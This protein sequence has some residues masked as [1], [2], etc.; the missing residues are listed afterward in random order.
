M[1]YVIFVFVSSLLEGYH[2]DCSRC[3]S[4]ILLDWLLRS[5]NSV[6]LQSSDNLVYIN[7]ASILPV[8]QR[9]HCVGAVFDHPDRASNGACFKHSK[10]E[11]PLSNDAA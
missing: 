10:L 11:C 4:L 9:H 6:I 1:V 3:M 7:P 2:K 8:M 5:Q